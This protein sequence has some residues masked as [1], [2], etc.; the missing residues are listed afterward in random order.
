MG[1]LDLFKNKPRHSSFELSDLIEIIQDGICI[2]KHNGDLIYANPAAYKLLEIPF[3]KPLDSLNFFTSFIKTPGL[4]E[5]I[6]DNLRKNGMLKNLEMKIHNIMDVPKDVILN[7]NVLGD[8]T[9]D[10]YAIL[11]LFKDI[12]EI[13]LIQQQLLQSQKLESVGLMAS[14]IAHDFNN[15]LAAIIPN[16]ELIKISSPENSDNYKRAVTIE[17]SAARATEIANK[18]LTFTRNQE[19]YREWVH[20]ND[21]IKSSIDLVQSSLPGDIQ[22]ISDLATDLKML[23]A[24]PTQLEQVLI[25]LILNAKDAMPNGGTIF[26]ETKN[27]TIDERFQHMHLAPGDYVKMTV[28]DTGSGI[29]PEIITK[30]FDPFFTT[31]EIGKGTGLGL[32]MVYGIVQNHNGKVFVDSKVGMGTEFEIYLPA[33]GKQR[34][35]TAESDEQERITQNHKSFLIIDDEQNVREVLG[36]ILQF[37]GHTVF[38]ADS[39][40]KGVEMYQKN[41]SEIDY[42][43]LDMRMPKMDGRATLAELK[44]INPDVKVIATSGFDASH[45]KTY[46]EL[47]LVG[48]LKK[49]Y[50][51]QRLAAMLK[52][53][54]DSQQAN[55]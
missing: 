35:K 41:L 10:E 44:K 53:I 34:P 23:Y 43:I 18:L 29:P 9:Q 14:G 28:R 24:D 5:E 13:K 51:I 16:A 20:L 15:I 40:R 27:V 49:P 25:N 8:F 47:G 11:F 26:I 42:I 19:N 37:L 17:K 54:F 21:I 1:L 22:I 12:T 50:N 33:G 45:E 7:A 52:K 30:I 6:V 31:K 2:T 3:D 32:S 46:K 55:L 39:G 4:I 36:D 38:L 48:F